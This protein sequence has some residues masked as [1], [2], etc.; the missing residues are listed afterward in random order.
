MQ[1]SHLR[2]RLKF[3]IL[4]LIRV[5][6][7]TSFATI[8]LNVLSE[9]KTDLTVDALLGNDSNTHKLMDAFNPVSDTFLFTEVKFKGRTD[10]KFYFSARYK[11]AK[12][13]NDSNSDWSKVKVDMAY[14]SKIT[15]K[16]KK[17]TG[18]QL[19]LSF[20]KNDTNY[21]SKF[22]G[23]L[24]EFGGQSLGDRYDA[25]IINLNGEYSYKTNATTMLDFRYQHRNKKY[26]SYNI[27]G[28]SNLD[29]SHNQL[30]VDATFTMS[31]TA[32]FSIKGDFTKRV[33]VDRRAKDLT[34][35]DIVGTD[36][37]YNL[38]TLRGVYNYQPSKDNKWKYTA[39]LGQRT[40]S[41]AGYW[42]S[43]SN[44][45]SIATQQIFGDDHELSVKL[46]YAVFEYDNRVDTVGIDLE[47]LAKANKGFAL[48]IEHRWVFYRQGQS[49][50]ATY[51]ILEL[52]S[53]TSS[54][55]EYEYQRNQ[56]SFGVRWDMN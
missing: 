31:K 14:K 1:T 36:L 2:K 17:K 48:D 38:F 6:S 46:K 44:S 28:I 45:F 55:P 30:G 5:I 42:D 50:V 10:K 34:G 4:H 41:Q 43:K 27:V 3:Q 37:E 54:T 9:T 21:V 52:D 35:I 49:E 53:F 12:Y 29:Y 19:A 22:T 40:D 39:K 8:S 23:Q 16:N 25:N 20:N 24:A 15:Q 13:S 18:Y 33:Y 26:E 11:G 7:L 51:T 47:E 56:I 32:D